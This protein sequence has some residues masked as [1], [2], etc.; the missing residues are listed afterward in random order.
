MKVSGDI[1]FQAGTHVD[2]IKVKFDDWFNWVKPEVASFSVGV[3]NLP[4]RTAYRDDEEA[5]E[6]W[7]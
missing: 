2:G 6:L 7:F 3:E 4:P 1:L 5:D